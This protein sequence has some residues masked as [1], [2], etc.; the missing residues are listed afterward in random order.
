MRSL[1]VAKERVREEEMERGRGEKDWEGE[2]RR[3]ERDIVSGKEGK[4]RIHFKTKPFQC[5]AIFI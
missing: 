1:V 2:K 3:E 4:E 5:K